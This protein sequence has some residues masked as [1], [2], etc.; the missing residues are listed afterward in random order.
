M[1]LCHNQNFE[2][3]CDRRNVLVSTHAIHFFG[4]P[5][6]GINVTIL[7]TITKLV[8]IYKKTTDVMLKDLR[9]HS[10]QLENMQSLYV[11]ASKRI[12]T[13]FFCEGYATSGIG[14]LGKMVR[15]FHANPVAHW[16]I[17]CPLSLRRGPR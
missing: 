8:S 17:G 11:A 6:S 1:V 16:T 3:E 15:Y 13:I 14:N 12:R 10:S 4:T 9:A 2:S 5:H 7:E